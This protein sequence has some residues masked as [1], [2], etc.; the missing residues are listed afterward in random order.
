MVICA[1]QMSAFKQTSP[2][3]RIVLDVELDN[4]GSPYYRLQYKGKNVIL[5]S[6]LG[7]SLF[8][9]EDMLDIFEVDST[10]KTSFDETW[11][12]VWGE[13]KNI[14]NHYNEL[15]VSLKQKNT[16]RIMNLRFRVYDEGIGLRYEFPQ[17]KS[18]N[19]FVIKEKVLSA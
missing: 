19:Y 2:S 11:Q 16:G 14:R 1:L 18:L 12:P 8:D 15:F 10:N 3:G 4:N 9:A 17:Q 13:T 6:K 7:F 5:S